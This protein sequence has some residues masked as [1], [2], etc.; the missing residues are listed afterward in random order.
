MNRMIAWRYFESVEVIVM[1]CL[2]GMTTRTSHMPIKSPPSSTNSRNNLDLERC[3]SHHFAVSWTI[4]REGIWDVTFCQL[5]YIIVLLFYYTSEW[6]GVVITRRELVLWGSVVLSIVGGFARFHNI[7]GLDLGYCVWICKEFQSKECCFMRSVWTFLGKVDTTL[8][9]ILNGDISLS[10]KFYHGA[11]HSTHPRKQFGEK[12]YNCWMDVDYNIQKESSLHELIFGKHSF[13]Q[14]QGLQHLIKTMSWEE[15][16]TT[17]VRG[18]DMD[19]GDQFT[20]G[21]DF[22]RPPE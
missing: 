14:E 22:P 19:V 12:Y 1:I 17:D 10:K 20:K 13:V 8:R 4:C 6:C 18:C 2:D 9:D 15:E 11:T 16:A 3:D 7:E 5:F 21:R